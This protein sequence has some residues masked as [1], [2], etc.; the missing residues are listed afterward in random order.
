MKKVFLGLFVAGTMMSFT[1]VKSDA[2]ENDIDE[3]RC[4]TYR[5]VTMCD[6]GNNCGNARAVYEAFK[7]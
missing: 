3:S 1:T 2:A 7:R 5:T 6:S 4:C